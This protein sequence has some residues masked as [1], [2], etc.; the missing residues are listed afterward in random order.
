MLLTSLLSPDVER[1]ER[2]GLGH[3]WAGYVY[4][5]AKAAKQASMQ[6][7]SVDKYK[8]AGMKWRD[9]NAT[10]HGVSVTGEVDEG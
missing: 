10:R 9:R 2:R 5:A 6:H 3:F 8:P 1:R 7:A 4:K